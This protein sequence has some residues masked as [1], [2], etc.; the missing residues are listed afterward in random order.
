MGAAMTLWPCFPLRN[1]F[2]VPGK[3]HGSAMS[4]R[5]FFEL[6]RCC[7]SSFENRTHSSERHK[8]FNFTYYGN[9]YGTVHEF[10]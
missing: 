9:M 8:K 4:L 2:L 1:R 3:A 5:P 7:S 10:Y 6:H